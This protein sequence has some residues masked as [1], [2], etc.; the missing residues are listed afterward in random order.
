MSGIKMNST[1]FTSIESDS[2]ADNDKMVNIDSSSTAHLTLN[3]S[4]NRPSTRSTRS[5]NNSSSDSYPP[6]A[7]P[8]VTVLTTSSGSGGL[9]NHHHH[10]H[11][12][13][14]RPSQLITGGLSLTNR[15]HLT[16]HQRTMW[17][18]ANSFEKLLMLTVIILG[19][20]TIL[21]FISLVSVFL[22]QKHQNEIGYNQNSSKFKQNLNEDGCNQ[23]I[24]K[25][26]PPLKSHCMTPDCV[27][28]AASVIEAIDLTV[29]PCD[30]FYVS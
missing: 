6:D 10:H 18:R 12:S 7:S 14:T 5:S 19:T 17:S 21:L 2:G 28:V 30:D 20:T 3:A 1:S 13:L 8:S 25:Q 9:V 4:M 11:S 27:K 16:K 15:L 26:A 22:A 29:D 24:A 23:L